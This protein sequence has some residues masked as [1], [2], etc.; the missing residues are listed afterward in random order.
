VRYRGICPDEESNESGGRTAWKHNAFADTVV[1]CGL[2][3]LSI[4][5]NVEECEKAA[6]ACL[7]QFLAQSH[8]GIRLLLLSAG[9]VAMTTARLHSDCRLNCW[10][11]RTLPRHAVTQASLHIDD[12]SMKESMKRV[13]LINWVITCPP[14]QCRRAWLMMLSCVCNTPRRCMCNVTH[15][16]AAR[17]G[18]PVVL[19]PVR[20]TSCLKW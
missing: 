9:D 15:Q 14:T 17:D 13:D 20:A 1:T 12:W 8:V 10:W 6:V 7:H 2:N 3:I 16:G 19:R 11:W 4:K 5:W 18:G